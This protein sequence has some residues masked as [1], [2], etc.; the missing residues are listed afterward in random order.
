MQAC[1]DSSAA[2][3]LSALLSN[4]K[5]YI[6]PAQEAPGVP[7][8][9][10]KDDGH[11]LVAHF[12]CQRCTFA[13]YAPAVSVGAVVIVAF[14]TLP[15]LVVVLDLSTAQRDGSILIGNAKTLLSWLAHSSTRSTR[16]QAPHATRQSSRSRLSETG[17]KKLR[18]M[19]ARRSE[20][21]Q[22]F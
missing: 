6:P 13:A 10:V 12:I 4:D 16:P 8:I 14:G 7:R 9:F 15:R 2:A 20:E 18:S 19:A 11:L 22:S 5:Q 21:S 17:R 3:S 1:V